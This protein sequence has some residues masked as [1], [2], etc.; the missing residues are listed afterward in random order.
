MK[1]WVKILLIA[2]CALLLA[3]LIWGLCF[4]KRIND[5][6]RLF[7]AEP[8]STPA[9]EVTPAPTAMAEATLAPTAPPTPTPVPTPG[10]EEYLGAQADMDFM[11]NRV[12]VLALGIDESAERADWGTYR[13][14]TMML[15]TVDFSDNSVALLSIPRDSYVKIYNELGEIAK[16]DEPMAKINNAFAFGGGA[17]RKGFDYACMTVSKLLDVPVQHYVCVNMPVVKQM[18]DAMGGVDYDMDIDFTMNGRAYSK[19]LQ[20][21]DGQAVLDYCRMRKDSSDIV[22]VDRQQRMLALILQTMKSTDQIRNIP[23]IY[24]AGQANIETDMSFEQI[25]AL[26]LIAARMDMAQLSR[27]TVP[28]SAMR[29][30]NR[31]CVG[32]ETEKLASMVQKLFGKKN[33]N[34]DPEIDAAYLQA[35]PTLVVADERFI[36]PDG[37]VQYYQV[38]EMYYVLMPGTN[39][40]HGMRE[41]EFNAL[42]GRAQ[43]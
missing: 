15:V 20:H 18:V 4:Y 42:I 30:A 7:E 43:R 34:I 23:A 17:K 8:T 21:M 27:E 25:C 14:D 2:L 40:Y 3:G 24:Q 41:A 33:V 26:A 13:T 12:N 28:V 35:M 29:I 22:R 16:E 10:T 11:K 9:V 39:E 19:G 32:V 38:E 1:T 36:S 5:P 31:S 37:T 6:A